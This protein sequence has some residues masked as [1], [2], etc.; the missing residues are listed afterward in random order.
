[1]DKFIDPINQIDRELHCSHNQLSSKI[2]NHESN[3]D[4][5]V[6]KDDKD[7]WNS[8]ADKS[9]VDAEQSKA[10]SYTDEQISAVNE[11]VAN[12]LQDYTTKEYSDSLIYKFNSLMTS[13]NVGKTS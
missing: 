3:L 1:M 13:S 2:R 12:T 8:K 9:Y 11:N 5:H 4:I 6:T 7:L 10:K